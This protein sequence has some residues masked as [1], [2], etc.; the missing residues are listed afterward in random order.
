M[1]VLVIDDGSRDDTP[2]LAG[3]LGEAGI[4]YVRRPHAGATATR[5]TGA[6]YAK[7]ELL[8]FV[9]DDVEL[10]PDAVGMLASAHRK[11]RRAVVVGHLLSPAPENRYQRLRV[12]PERIVSN[13]YSEIE[14]VECFTGLLSV[15][16]EAFFA[17]GRFQ[18]PTG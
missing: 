16:R 7:G 11:W 17:L 8:V 14:C 3:A 18:D 10:M 15:N 1:E 6:A 4:V 2:E 12:I 9:D 13:G 5:N